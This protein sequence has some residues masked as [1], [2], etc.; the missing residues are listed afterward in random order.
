MTEQAEE[1][2]PHSLIFDGKGGA[3]ITDQL[4]QEILSKEDGCFWQHLDY[5][6]AETYQ[7]LVE[8]YR[9][10]STIADALCDED[11]RPRYFS[12]D[13][14]MALILRGINFNAGSEPEDMV[15]IRIWIDERR[16]ITLSHR[17]LKAVNDIYKELLEGKGPKNTAQ[18]L[19]EIADKISEDIAK[20]ADDIEDRTDDLEESVIDIDSLKDFELRSQISSLRHEIISLRRYVVPQREIFQNLQ[21]D[22][23]TLFC[24]KNKS[25]FREISSRITKAVEDLE[26]AKDHLSVF[27][28]ELQSKISISMSRIMYMIS[29]VTVI[30]I[31]LGLIT[32]LLG[33]NVNGIPFAESKFAFLGVCLIL[34]FLLLIAYTVMKRLRWL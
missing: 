7:I 17:K 29:L 20:A 11:S 9:L 1:H 22:K 25:E 3:K 33:I 18:C 26:Y 5:Q 30:F 27:H 23:T 6:N 16:I 14:G 34:G 31:P 8:N 19:L 4:S 13:N 24:N 10:D 15:S 2:S 32:S 21:N 12:Q 28:E